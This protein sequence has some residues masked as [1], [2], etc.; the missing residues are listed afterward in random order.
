MDNYEV[1]KRIGRG[2]YGT[3]FVAKDRRNSR[4]YCL[5]QIQMEAFSEEE[6]VQAHEE[7]HLLRKLDHP[8]IVKYHEHFIV[9]D[10]LCV[11]M[12]YCEGGDLAQVIKKRAKAEQF[13]AE[14]EVLDWFIQ[15]VLALDYV[16]NLKILHRDLKTSNIFISKA[17][18]VRMGDFGIAKV[19][20][21]TS[22]AA[23]TVIGTPYYMSPEVCQGQHYDY[24]SDV[25]ALGCIL[26][27]ICA[28]QQAWSGSN[29]LGLVYKIVQEKQ[30]R[31]PDN[32]SEELK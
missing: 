30:P 21:G 28:L 25:W 2:N 14:H 4:Y 15:L 31:L 16:H 5:K 23:S 26:Y 6:R 32:Y 13:F 20:D 3:V 27:E 19:L 7:V 11:V 22:G 1:G 10:T 9:D 24:K 18:H 12:A 29:L 17:G 8:G